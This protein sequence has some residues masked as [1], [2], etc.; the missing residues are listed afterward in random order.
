MTSSWVHLTNL[1]NGAEK[2]REICVKRQRRDLRID[3]NKINDEALFSFLVLAR[4]ERR[5]AAPVCG[6]ENICVDIFE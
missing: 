1:V 4:N 6:R 3:E 2:V 5:N